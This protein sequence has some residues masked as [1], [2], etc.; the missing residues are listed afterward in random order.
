MSLTN[1][2]TYIEPTAGTSLNTAR[3][4]QND[5]FRSLLSNFYSTSAPTAINFTAA[6][7]GLDTPNGMLFRSATTGALYISDSINKKSS[8][9][10]GNFTRIGI[11]NRVEHN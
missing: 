9:I 5:T 3:L 1:S 11:G 2:N 7:A 8:P 10:G 6:G 4:Q